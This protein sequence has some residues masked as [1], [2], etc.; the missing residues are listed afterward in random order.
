MKKSRVLSMVMSLVIALSTMFSVTFADSTNVDITTAIKAAEKAKIM[1]EVKKLEAKYD[2]VFTETVDESLTGTLSLNS[3]EEIEAVLK[4]LTKK[5]S[6]TSPIILGDS[7]LA[8][9][10]MSTLATVYASADTIT[11]WAPFS[12]WGMTGLLTWRNIAFDY[13]Y[14]YVGSSQRF[15]A[16]AIVP[17]TGIS[18]DLTGLTFANWV[19]L[20]GTAPTYDGATTANFTV[21][22]YYLLGIDI[23][24]YT[25]GAH[26]NDTWT[27][28]Y[29]LPQ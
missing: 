24:G 21:K 23:N 13:K 27:R 29:T 6:T 15:I 25:L 12:G 11:W 7:K 19:Q 16:N 28:S 20:S 22:G 3:V 4:E 8:V 10:E 26:I 14:Y 5:D 17:N 1:K 18:S 2:V 9:Q